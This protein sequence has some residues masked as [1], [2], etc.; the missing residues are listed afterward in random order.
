[1]KTVYRIKKPLALSL[2]LGLVGFGINGPSFAAPPKSLTAGTHAAANAV[3]ALGMDLL[4]QGVPPTENALISPYS[5]QSALAMTYAGADGDNKE[6]MAKALHYADAE[7]QLH[8]SFAALQSALAEVTRKTGTLAEQSNRAGRPAE[9]VILTVANRLFGDSGYRFE[10]PFLDLLKG[11]YHAPFEL[12]DFRGASE[13]SRIAINGWVAEQTQKRIVD[14]I[15]GGGIDASTRLVLVNAIYLKAPWAKPFKAEATKPAPFHVDGVTPKDVPTMTNR[16][17][18]GHFHGEGYTAVTIPYNGSDVHFLVILP[19]EMNGLA[20]LE[21]KLTPEILASC[22]L[23]KTADVVLHLPKLKL[24]PP[25]MK[26]SA[27]LKSLGLV[28]AFSREPGVANFN[29]MAIPQQGGDLAISEVFHKTF[30][31]LDEKG[32]EAAAATA[33][34]MVFK[35]SVEPPPIEVRVDHPFLFAIQHRQSGACLFLGRVTNP[36]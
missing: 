6:E 31:K 11:T 30:L 34:V 29:R 7:E 2:L 36:Q 27:A 1:M 3:N 28:R 24:E 23:M 17:S 8:A 32:T 12:M 5:I 19:D 20:E 25:L 35:T 9:P 10:Q 18:Y 14:L 15:P 22:A 26:L 21:T 33:V 16:D 4:K 13:P